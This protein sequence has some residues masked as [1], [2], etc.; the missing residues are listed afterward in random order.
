MSEVQGPEV[1]T[2]AATG[3]HAVRA[4]ELPSHGSKLGPCQ[5]SPTPPQGLG[6]CQLISTKA[7]QTQP[8]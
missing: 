2:E 3:C 8:T 4:E 6:A 7:F 1:P 5:Q